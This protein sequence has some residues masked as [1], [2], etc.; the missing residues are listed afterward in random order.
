MDSLGY[1]GIFV[2]LVGLVG[3]LW[4]GLVHRRA[5]AQR[6]ASE[7]WL[8]APGRI[9]AAE[10][11]RGGG[12]T[13]SH[14]AYY[15]P[16]VRY[17]YVVNGRE[18]EGTRLRFGMP[19]ARSPGGVQAMLRPYP[20][21]ATVQ[22]RYD[23]DNPDQSVLEPGKGSANMLIAA[24]ACA[25]LSLAGVAIA[26]LAVKG[27]FTAD[28][29]GH[30]QVRF[31]VQGLAYEGELDAVHGAGPLTLTYQGQDGR[32]RAIE[33]CTLTRNGDRVLVRCANARL[34]E[35]T[36]DYSPD[37]FDLAFQGPSRLAGSVS[38]PASGNTPGGPSGTAT[39]TR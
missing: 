13:S 2:A 31:E 5:S 4:S 37:N 8:N 14:Y 9:V 17:T 22:V 25:F 12:T 1:L 28:V 29:S 38:S 10:V 26:V 7:R 24:V 30:W 19:S 15:V 34:V 27:V 18:R 33:D 35:G 16:A 6:A 21:G 20:P 36:G 3:G 23:P 39:F 11:R 32:R